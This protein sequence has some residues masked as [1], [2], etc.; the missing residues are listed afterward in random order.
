[1]NVRELLEK[2][3][4][5]RKE[6]STDQDPVIAFDDLEVLGWDNKIDAYLP[7]D[8]VEA[9]PGPPFDFIVIYK[10]TDVR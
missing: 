2:I 7:V 5:V 10:E 8:E 1:M 4:E 3:E 6:Y 9:I